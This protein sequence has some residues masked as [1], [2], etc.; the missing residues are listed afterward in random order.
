MAGKKAIEPRTESGHGT[1]QSGLVGLRQVAI[2]AGVSTA[3]VSRAINTPHLVSPKLRE[4]INEAIDRLGWVPDGTARA[5][6][7]KRSSTIGAVF[8]TLTHGDF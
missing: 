8:P 5:L 3:T 7:T 2:A 4:R 6:A 1:D